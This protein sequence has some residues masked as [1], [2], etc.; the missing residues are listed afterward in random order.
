MEPD[1]KKKKRIILIVAAALLLIVGIILFF[2]FRNQITATTM[3]LLRIE[4]DVSLEESGKTKSVKVDLRLHNDDALSTATKSL[5]SIGLDDTKIVT[6]D[7]LSRAEFNQKGRK[8]NLH[9]TAGSLFFDVKKP[10]EEDETFDIH[11]STMVVGIRGT[12]GWVSVKG[13]HE[14]LIVTDGV[15]HV[16]GTNPVT[17]ET[18]EIDVYAGQRISTYLYNDREIDSIMFELE[19]ITERQLPE[20]VLERLREDE[21]LLERVCRQTNWDKPWILGIIDPL[22]PTPTPTPEAGEKGSG[23]GNAEITPTPS[24]TP[25]PTKT[26]PKKTQQEELEELLALMQAL[27]TPTPTPTPEPEPVQ[28]SSND[29]EEEEPE[30]TPTA[31]VVN[32]V[33]T[34]TGGASGTFSGDIPGSTFTITDSNGNTV[35]SG[36]MTE[37]V[38]YHT[39]GATYDTV[40]IDYALSNTV[41]LPLTLNTPGGASLNVSNYTNL[42][43]IDWPNSSVDPI[44]VIESNGN[45]IT[46][47]RTN[48]IY[49]YTDS[50]GNNLFLAG[51]TPNN[52]TDF[53][54]E[55]QALYTP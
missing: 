53:Q 15:V 27:I 29:D 34:L 50:S 45:I 51:A 33:N 11:T 36:T 2:Y 26:T 39:P 40:A 44:T 7:E 54:Y 48:G 8:L 10:L 47:D 14:T 28:S 18:K 23:S 21:E 19:N 9:L 24:P 5:V 32:P 4:G 13:E 46:R 52:D 31:A 41:Y 22:A 17:G 3:R 37:S 12:S 38:P 55:F 6:L 1:S 43:N 16:I 30:P 49:T 42:Q 25:E 20:F 35:Y